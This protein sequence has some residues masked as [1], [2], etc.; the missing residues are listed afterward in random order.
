[1]ETVQTVSILIILDGAQ[2]VIFSH[3]SF[4]GYLSFNPYYSGWCSTSA[5]KIFCNKQVI[6]FQSLLF[7]MVLNKT[8]R[9]ASHITSCI[10]FQSLLFWMVLNKTSLNQYVNQFKPGFNPYYSGWCSTSCYPCMPNR[11]HCPVSILIILDGAQQVLLNLNLQDLKQKFQSLLFWM[12]LNKRTREG[13]G[14]LSLYR[15][16]PYYSGWCSTSITHFFQQ[17]HKYGVSILIILDGAQQDYKLIWIIT[18]V[19][20]FNPYYSGWCSTRT[21][22]RHNDEI[23]L[24]FQS[25]LFWMVLNK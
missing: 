5:I 20:S 9:S 7:W 11:H 21:I 12:V 10:T 14:S 15:F 16:N 4:G 6:L 3:S 24:L 19:R 22:T 2:Q 25:L 17:V 1:M 8:C 18:N 23:I 13:S